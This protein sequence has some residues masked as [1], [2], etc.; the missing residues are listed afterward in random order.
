M[1]TKLNVNIKHE[2]V[3]NKGLIFLLNNFKAE[4]GIGT[5]LYLE[6]TG[7]QEKKKE[8]TA[9]LQKNKEAYIK[10]VSI[11]HPWV[12]QISSTKALDQQKLSWLKELVAQYKPSEIKINLLK[13]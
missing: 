2:H 5:V 3:T 12:K 8:A 13:D 10:F 6:Y 7:I 1:Q 9:F 11:Q 4:V